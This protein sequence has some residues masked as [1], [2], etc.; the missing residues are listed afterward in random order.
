MVAGFVALAEFIGKSALR[1][2]GKKTGIV[3]ANL[4]HG[5]IAEFR[6]WV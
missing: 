3:V 5:G 1:V 4:F 6:P 2:P